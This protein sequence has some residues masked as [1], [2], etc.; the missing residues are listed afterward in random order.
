MPRKARQSALRAGGVDHVAR[1]SSG[2]DDVRKGVS[3]GQ[4]PC[5]TKGRQR[6]GLVC[7]CM[8]RERISPFFGYVVAHVFRRL[9]S[10]E[11]PMFDIKFFV[12]GNAR[13]KQCQTRVLA[14]PGRRRDK[15]SN[16]QYSWTHVWQGE[17]RRKEGKS[18]SFGEARSILR[19]PR[20]ECQDARS[21]RQA[22]YIACPAPH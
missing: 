5:F 22:N 4:K 16:R 8:R 11:R 19:H 6:K 3:G 14:V 18:S 12:A 17:L 21:H 2:S 10:R 1:D 7:Y 9:V 20:A 13:G 15:K